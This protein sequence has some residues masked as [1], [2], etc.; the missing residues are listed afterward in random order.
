MSYKNPPVKLP[1]NQKIKNTVSTEDTAKEYK[2]LTSTYFAFIDVLGFKNSFNKKKPT[3]RKVFEYFNSLM[4]QMRCLKDDSDNCYAGQTSDSL[5]FYTTKLNYLIC[6]INIFLHFNIY[7]MSENI[8]FR[9]GIAKGTLYISKPYQF[10]GDCVINSF[11]LEENIAQMPR[12]AIDKQTMS[13]LKGKIEDI[14]DINHEFHRNF[15]NMF[16]KVVLSDVRDYLDFPSANC[17]TIDMTLIKKAKDKIIKNIE[18][19]ELDDKNYQKYCF[20]L[21]KCDNM[22]SKIQNENKNN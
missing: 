2:E 6:F 11:L 5:Y 15:L 1:D 8:F 9:G 16:S 20:L 18:S 13:D 4:D 14:W 7:A 12:I 10:Y 3:I 17:K 21:K 22:I 19:L